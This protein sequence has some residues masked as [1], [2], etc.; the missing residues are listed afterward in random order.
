[1]VRVRAIQADDCGAVADLH[2][3]SLRTHLAGR[4]AHEALAAYYA[5]IV[6]G[7][8]GTGFVAV[9]ENQDVAGFV[10]GIWDPERLRQAVFRDSGPRLVLMAAGFAVSHPPTAIRMLQSRVKSQ[11]EPRLFPPGAYELRPLVVGNTH[12]GSGIAT[13]LVERVLSDALDRGWSQVYLKTES[14]NAR[15]NAL[16]TKF[17]FQRVPSANEFN[18]FRIAAG[19]GSRGA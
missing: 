17:G 5:S 19:N 2:L 11:H 16:Y 1:M 13:Q 15:A 18:V 6:V 10:C 7:D 4:Y 14:D 12:R 8:G 3:E 9:A